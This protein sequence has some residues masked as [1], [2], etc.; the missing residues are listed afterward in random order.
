MKK[1]LIILICVFL[2]NNISEAQTEVS[3]VVSS[4]ATW[5]LANSPYTV[6]GNILVASDVTLTIEAGVTVKINSGLYLKIQGSVVAIGTESDKITITSNETSP[7]KGDW[8][9]IWLASTSTSFDSNDNYVSGTIFNHC[10]ISYANEGLRLDDSSFYLVNSELTENNIG[11]NFR[12]VINSIIDNNNFNNNN[13]GTSTS[14]GTEENGVGS[15]TF[16][17]FLNNTFKNNTGHGLS[18]GGYRN[19]ANNNLIKNNISINNGGNGFYFGWG[20][21]VRGF[22]DNTIE[23][24]IIYNNSG[25]GI[26]VGRDSNILKKNFIVNNEGSGINISGTYIYEGLTIENNIISG[27]LGYGLDLTS[28]TNSLIRHNSILNSGGNSE[29]P[30]LGIPNSYITSN[31]NTITF[32]TIDASKNNAIELK[33]GPN[34]F[35]NNN[36]IRTKGNYVFKLLTDNDSDINAENNYWGTSTES[37]IQAAIYDYSDDFEL[38]A[39][40]YTP[41]STTLNTAAP[42]SPP[43]SVMKVTSG[44]DVVLSWTANAEADVAGYKLYYGTPTGY[45]YATSIDLGNVTTYTVTGGD[46]AT[47]YA[48]TAY[49]TS[50]DGTD[51]MVDGNESWYSKANTL[52]DLPTNIVLE[53]APRKS[54]LSWTLSATE[55]IASYEIYRGLSAQPTTLYYTTTSETENN[56][57]DQNLTVGE[58]YYYR[59][60][61]VDVNGVSSNFSEDFAVTI[62]TSWTVS[63]E[64][65]S[66]NGFGSAENPFI[67]IQDAVDETVNNDIVVVSP[68]TYIENVLIFEKMISVITSDPANSPSTTV[69]DGGSNGLPVF[70]LD[71]NGSTLEGLSGNIEISGFTL[72]NGLSPTYEVPGGLLVKSTNASNIDISISHLII[73]NNQATNASGGS[74]F[75]YTN[76]IEISDVIYRNNTGKGSSAMGAFNAQFSLNRGVFHNNTSEGYTFDFWHNSS[77][78]QFSTI[79]NSLIRNNSDNGAFN[80]MDGII[81]NTTIVD[82]GSQMKF[83]GSSSIVNTIINTGQFISSDSGLLK[84]H[85]SHIEDGQNSID[86]FP[87][88]LTYENNLEGDIYFTDAENLDFTLSEYSPGTGKGL[89]SITLYD[90]AYDLS[91]NKDLNLNNRPLPEGTNIDIGAYESSLGASTH[92]NSIYVSITE[93]S[94]DGSVGL[95]TQPFETIQAAV[96]YALD[97]DTIYVL[98]GTYPG[99]SSIINKGVNFISTIPLGAIVNNNVDGSNAFTFS[100]NTGVFYSTI[101]GFD[102]N[103]TSTGQAYG[104]RA[105]DHHYVNLYKSKISNF[106]YATSTGASSIQA[107]N[108]LFVSNRGT[109]YNDQ[110]STGSENIT[111]RLKNC[112]VINSESVHSAC[113][114]ISLDVINSIVL[115]SNTD[116]NAYTSPPNFNKVITNDNN[117][118]PQENSTWEVT[119]DQEVDI[120]FTDFNGGDYSLQ[121]FSPAIGY[122]FFPVSEDI[123]GGARPLPVGSSLDIGAYENILGSPLNGSPRFDAIADVSTNEDSGT[124][125]L[126]ILNVVDGDILETQNLTFSVTSDN[127]ALFELIEINYTQ[128]SETAILNY[129]PALDKNGT[130]TITVTLEDDAGTE[131]GGINSATKTFVI[132]ISPVNDQ[133]IVTD[134]SLTVDEGATV[135]T[136]DINEI[137]LLFN[138]VDVDEDVLTAILVTEPT[139][140]SLT[141]NSDGTFSYTHDSSETVSDSFTYKANDNSIDSNVATVTISINP[142]NDAPVVSNH[143]MEVDEG[144]I[145][146]SLDNSETSIL[147]NA[148]DIEEDLLSAIIETAPTYGTLVLETDG[149]FSYTHDG[150]DTLTD[151]FSFRAD[152]SNLTSEIGTV[153][154]SIN[155]VNDNNPTDIILSNNS[156]NENEDSANGFLIGQFTSIDLDLPS[157]SHTFEFVTGDGDTDNSSFVL[158]GNNLKTFTSFDFETQESL[159]I[160]VKTVDEENQTFEKVFTVSIINANDISIESVITNSYCEGE[161]ANGSIT[162]SSISNTTGNL[163]FSWSATNGGS[164]PSGQEGIQNL[165][166]L[167]DGSYTVVISDATEFT[168]TE[169]F[170]INLIEQYNDLSVCYVSSDEDDPTKN[171][172]FINNEGN[173]NV[174]SYEV[175]RE[176]SVANEYEVIGTMN[177]N[178]ISFL[179][180]E[181]NN[182]NRSYNYKVSLTDNCGDISESSSSHKTILLQSSI[183][184]DNSVNLNWSEYEGTEYSTYI[185][186]RKVNDGNYEELDAISSSN[187]SYNDSNA[188]VIF[189]N[190]YEYY[191]SIAVD[192]CNVDQGRNEQFNT[193]EIKSNRLFVSDGTASVDDFNDQNQFE[194]YP[195]PSKDNLNIK[196]SHRVN[197]IKGE[198]YNSIGQL[199]LSTNDTKFS[200]K[201]LSP[202]VYFIKIYTN[203]G[204]M[205]KNF[206]KQ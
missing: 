179:D 61:V 134:H 57:I 111:P 92:N 50:L 123:T 36:F 26:T 149:T 8:D 83:R 129:T 14:A 63:K 173:Y 54:K 7:T 172:V 58:T 62:P 115:I 102:I 47:E 24:N 33:Y 55:N 165:S 200:I 192:Q 89:N 91:S 4:D 119:P 5:S 140:G 78:S 183:A 108:C 185:I 176:T 177:S 77:S 107:E 160:R 74:Y 66:E 100:S 198:I 80:I 68:G 64:T 32:N 13:S 163:E 40:D 106:T 103:K 85:N 135:E 130:A 193:V 21:V 56:Y 161:T 90:I 132:T 82:N 159:S 146:S 113:S 9:K 45:S 197:Y 3:G 38:G 25:N 81:M 118:I 181:S 51:D 147:Y 37:E 137:N 99:G 30:S 59:I 126:D 11:I 116:Q 76:L 67:N 84:V 168:L 199:V 42:I 138:A 189:G 2:F 12:K 205:S 171:R 6:S 52:P 169:E 16:T 10:I 202:S 143:S 125:S 188:V 73:E 79:N 203:N 94:N 170:Q 29:S 191:V 151:S 44:S 19:N 195:N 95:E 60:K 48:I 190:S 157:D 178:E 43:T 120:Y 166:N 28:N 23:G 104:I 150:S 164:I 196:L 184:V 86:V 133:S 22:A 34:T 144:G 65:G 148:T 96:N 141:L 155:P 154:I 158:D 117:V 41:F 72:K 187:T 20:D 128:G 127:E 31:D 1:N 75:Y 153:S 194:I 201:N 98:P 88:F 174:S 139:N 182:Q 15:F 53:G 121:D 142:V 93:G 114:T 70:K 131:G 122:G 35:N 110:C 69:I 112:T 105:T 136:L 180:E 18:F 27:N 206:I 71:V 87:S 152:D 46:I 49:D 175:L 167:K 17:K 109:I 186:Y 145:S 124:Q 101:T 204:V 39:V 162:I 97:G 156:I